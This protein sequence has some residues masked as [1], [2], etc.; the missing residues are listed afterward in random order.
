ME[1]KTDPETPKKKLNL[2]CGRMILEGW[3]NLDLMELPGVDVTFDLDG[4]KTHPLPFAENSIDEIL[5]CHTL[6]HLTNTL[7]FMQDLHRVAKPDASALF[8]VPYGSS[9]A[10]LE[11][12]T[13]VRPYFFHSFEYF[14]QPFYWRADYGYRGDW[15]VEKINLLM[16]SKLH[17]GK[18]TGRILYEINR[19]RNTVL[20]MTVLLRAVKP[21]RKP[22]QEY[23]S[24]PKIT[25]KFQKN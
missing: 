6:E 1:K 17:Q 15:Q 10:A 13:H 9:D 7:D 21:V 20:E 18:E 24:T 4:C 2:G 5:C 25:V 3:I 23:R 14:A 19:L 16:D 12:P 22:Q 8:M 11:D